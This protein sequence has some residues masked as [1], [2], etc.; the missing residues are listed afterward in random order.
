MAS[1][2]PRPDA[3]EDLRL[4]V[5]DREAVY[6]LEIDPNELTPGRLAEISPPA[7]ANPSDNLK[8]LFEMPVLFYT[9]VL[10]LYMTR[11]ADP[12][13]V[14]MAWTFVALRFLHSGIHV[15]YNRV[16]HRFAAYFVGSLLLWCIW[17][18]L[19]Y[20]LTQ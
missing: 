8:N 9:A 13:F 1:A 18:R 11:T 14:I 16:V 19:V 20:T 4:V 6:T 12:L 5:D 10:T 17:A 2:K 3:E 15:T 7:V